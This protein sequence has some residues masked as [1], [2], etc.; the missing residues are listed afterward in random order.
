MNGIRRVIEVQSDL[1]QRGRLEDEYSNNNRKIQ[2]RRD[3]FIKDPESSRFNSI[4][5]IEDIQ[6]YY[7]KGYKA[8]S[9]YNDPTAHFRM[10]REELAQASQDNIE[11]VQFPTGETAMKIEGL[12]ETNTWIL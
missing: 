8:L 9:V 2:D 1:Y 7:N 4:E 12:G 3:F 5:E 10:I 11:K 6:N